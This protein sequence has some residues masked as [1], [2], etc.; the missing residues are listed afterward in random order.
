[1]IF[2][3]DFHL[4]DC[5]DSIFQ[6]ELNDLLDF[7]KFEKY[8]ETQ[9]VCE[10]NAFRTGNLLVKGPGGI[11]VERIYNYLFQQENI[12]NDKIYIFARNCVPYWFHIVEFGEEGF[13]LPNKNDQESFCLVIP[14]NQSHKEL[15]INKTPNSE[16]VF[17]FKNPKKFFLYNGSYA[18]KI[19]NNT[20]IKDV[21]KVAYISF[22]YSAEKAKK[23]HL[24]ALELARTDA[25][26]KQKIKDRKNILKRFLNK[27]FS[28]RT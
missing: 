25:L 17:S 28:K 9:S 18:R 2:P 1:M 27:I 24:D 8:E 23:N 6:K 5:V 10:K 26:I 15:R 4:H 22:T 20:D 19:I 12:F 13:E 11:F 14:L 7:Y 3:V 16:V 21:T